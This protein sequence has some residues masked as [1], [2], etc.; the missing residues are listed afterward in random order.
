M[1]VLASV[2]VAGT[3]VVPILGGIP[4]LQQSFGSR[5]FGSITP[6]QR[7]PMAAGAAPLIKPLRALPQK[8]SMGAFMN[9]LDVDVTIMSAHGRE[10]KER[11]D[12]DQAK[13]KKE[14]E[15]KAAELRAQ[16]YTQQGLEAGY[17]H[18][19]FHKSA[20]GVQ[21]CPGAATTCNYDDNHR[22]CAQML[23]EEGKP[24]EWG[25]AGSF[26]D[27]A[28]KKKGRPGLAQ[29]QAL[30]WD[31]EVLPKAIST[32]GG[33]SFC[34]DM[35]LIAG[36]TARVGCENMHIR[37]EATDVQYLV[38]RY[39]EGEEIGSPEEHGL[40]PSAA[41]RE[42][43]L[44]EAAECIESQ[45]SLRPMSLGSSS[46]DAGLSGEGGV[47]LVGIVAFAGALGALVA[48]ALTHKRHTHSVSPDIEPLLR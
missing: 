33:D 29:A 43:I 15:K 1:A 31:N 30:T 9:Q 40:A 28:G 4:A 38:S 8:I 19:P 44:L 24:L 25:N 20:D 42:E 3:L 26:W 48:V 22:V 23:D 21:S 7:Q 13:Q 11:K 35:W 6:Q 47:S 36:L 16:Q 17:I 34:T 14:E 46:Q 39:M 27:I 18:T 41:Q 32:N 12:K 45:C 10:K 37:C 2:I 5:M